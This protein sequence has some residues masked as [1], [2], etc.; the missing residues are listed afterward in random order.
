M[1]MHTG[2]KIGGKNSKLKIC[3][4]KLPAKKRVRCQL[5]IS[6]EKEKRFP[7]QHCSD[8]LQGHISIISHTA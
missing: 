5:N 1:A 3:Q 2:E 4:G 8:I 6:L 7:I